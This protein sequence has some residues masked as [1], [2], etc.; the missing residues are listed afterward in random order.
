[1]NIHSEKYHHD[2][3]RKIFSQHLKCRTE[4]VLPDD[5]IPA[6]P[7][8]PIHNG[9]ACLAEGCNYASGMKTTM[10][11]HCK[12]Q[13]GVKTIFREHTVQRFAPHPKSAWFPVSTDALDD[14]YLLDSNPD[15]DELVAKQRMEGV[16][17]RGAQERRPKIKLERSSVGSNFSALPGAS[18]EETGGTR[19]RTRL[20]KVRVQFFGIENHT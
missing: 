13:H 14:A 7:E 1:M 18:S 12:T 8:L 4:Y 2:T 10:L 9:F 16:R 15:L 5:I 19:K 11:V 3:L 20:E 6:I 17:S